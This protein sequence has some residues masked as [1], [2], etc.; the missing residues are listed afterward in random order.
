MTNGNYF[1]IYPK[2]TGKGVETISLDL[3]VTIQFL[4]IFWVLL[5][6]MCY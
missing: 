5:T 1:D 2:K 4:S 6:E 3:N